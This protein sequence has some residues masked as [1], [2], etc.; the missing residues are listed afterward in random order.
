[1]SQLSDVMEGLSESLP[2]QSLYRY[3]TAVSEE[4]GEVSGS[5]NKWM[6]GRTDKPKTADDILE[7]TAQLI[8][9][10]LLLGMQLGVPVDGL[11]SR[12]VLFAQSK[13]KELS[14]R[15]SNE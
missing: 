11:I 7:E 9:C 2:S 3:I 10:A 4:A 13:T 8:A 6:D 15:V 1:M 5:F 12:V 14:R